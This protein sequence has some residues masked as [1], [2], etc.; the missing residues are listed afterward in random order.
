[1]I[2]AM[3]TGVVRMTMKR[4]DDRCA[5]RERR[6]QA[7]GEEVRTGE[8]GRRFARYAAYSGCTAQLQAGV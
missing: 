4:R 8:R 3:A 2:E 6:G 5:G 1:M 7:V